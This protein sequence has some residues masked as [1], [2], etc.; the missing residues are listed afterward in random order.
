MSAYRKTARAAWNR[1]PARVRRTLRPAVKAVHRHRQLL[2]IVA[3]RTFDKEWYEAQRG[4]RFDSQRAAVADYLC[5][6]R[7]SY[8]SPHPLFEPEWLDDRQWASRST[9]PLV[10]F[11]RSNRTFRRSPHPLVDAWAANA[12]RDEGAPTAAAWRRLVRSLTPNTPLPLG[13]GY[14]EVTWSELRS[15]LVN[16]VAAWRRDQQLAE[17]PRSQLTWNRRVEVPASAS[18]D[19]LW[20][21][22]SDGRPFVSVVVPT[23]NRASLLARSIGS[24]QA[25]TWSDFEIIVV[26]DGSTDDTYHVVR[27]ICEFDTRV[28]L[29]TIERAGVSAARNRGIDEA[30]GELVA[31]L[32]TDN[33]W[34]PDFLRSMVEAIEANEWDLA[35]AVLRVE[36]RNGGYFRAFEGTHDHLL[37]GNYIDL[38]V[39]V[40]RASLLREIG[41]FDTTLRRAIDYDLVLRLS[42]RA[43]LHLVP[44]VGAV[45]AGESSDGHRISVSEPTSW[46]AVVRSRHLIDWDEVASKRREPD[47]VSVASSVPRQT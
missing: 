23:W 13:P 22:G 17:V 35:H 18:I 40:V 19:R 45:Y 4:R 11:L 7:R 26:D 37:V 6:P 24:V 33:T 2:T 28:R 1:T 27:G 16:E 36:D 41:G 44:V 42:R 34:E 5:Q 30:R 14:R 43:D 46:N 39:L 25:Q 20:R 47:R 21:Q 15:A 10:W 38:N 31:F 29:V 12:V 32:D 3:S 9:D 8:L